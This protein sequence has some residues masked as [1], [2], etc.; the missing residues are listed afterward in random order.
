METVKRGC[1]GTSGRDCQEFP[2]KGPLA[3]GFDLSLDR[4]RSKISSH[5]GGRKYVMTTVR[6]QAGL[7]C[8]TGCGPNIEGGL[9]TLCTCLHQIRNYASPC[10]WTRGQ[11]VAGFTSRDKKLGFTSHFLFYL[12]KVRW[13]YESHAELWFSSEISN[14]TKHAKNARTSQFGDV[15]EPRFGQLDLSSKRFEPAWYRIPCKGH[16]HHAPDDPDLWKKDICYKTKTSKRPAALLIGDPKFSFMWRTTQIMFAGKLPR[17]SK[18]D[19]QDLLINGL[20]PSSS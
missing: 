4:L 17:S 19:L 8:Q 15:Y 5:E 2:I 20:V 13:A 12:M 9:I 11:W 1:R 3:D 14:H 10:D 18:F 16:P 7:M 6:N